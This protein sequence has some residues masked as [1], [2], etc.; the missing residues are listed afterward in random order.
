MP[1]PSEA[2]VHKKG[3]SAYVDVEHIE[4]TATKH[5]IIM[6]DKSHDVEY[7]AIAGNRNRHVSLN[8]YD[9]TPHVATTAKK[10][11]HAVTSM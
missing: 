4:D 5:N 1:A 3:K 6:E 11:A 9:S 2:V 7:A 10:N 8:N